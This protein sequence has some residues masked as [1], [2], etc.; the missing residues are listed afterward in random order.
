MEIP[1]CSIISINYWYSHKDDLAI[2]C[3]IIMSEEDESIYF[4]TKQA[5]SG[6]NKTAPQAD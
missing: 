1:K 2:S 6:K 3:N 4:H 5:G